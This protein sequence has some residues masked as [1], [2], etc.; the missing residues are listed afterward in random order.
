MKVLDVDKIR[1]SV[2]VFVRDQEY[3]KEREG[4]KHIHKHVIKTFPQRRYACYHDMFLKDAV[5]RKL[6]EEIYFA[7]VVILIHTRVG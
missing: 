3:E 4:R 6:K 7:F 5:K 2:V 1:V